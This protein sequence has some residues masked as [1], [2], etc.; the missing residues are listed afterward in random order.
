MAE[1]LKTTPS[2]SKHVFCKLK[3]NRVLL[4]SKKS[5]FGETASG[6]EVINTDAQIYHKVLASPSF[7]QIITSTS[8]V[9]SLTPYTENVCVKHQIAT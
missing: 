8:Y 3:K 4:K 2:L 7:S 9:K 6:K 5:R 1:A